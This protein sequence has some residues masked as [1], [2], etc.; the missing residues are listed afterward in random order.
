MYID[1]QKGVF[2]LLVVLIMLYTGFTFGIAPDTVT[3]ERYQLTPAGLRLLLLTITVPLIG[4]WYAAFYGFAR[5]KAYASSIGSSP[6]G[7]AFRQLANGLMVLAVGLPLTSIIPALMKY[8]VAGNMRLIPAATIIEHY[9]DVAIGLIAFTLIG[10]GARMLLS[11]HR[12]NPAPPRKVAVVAG[13]VLFG[14]LFAYV[15]LRNP[16]IQTPATDVEAVYYLPDWL[17][18][19]TI[20]IPYLYIW[21]N[22]LTAAYYV[23]LY[24]KHVKGSLYKQSLRFLAWGLGGVIISSMLL[25][26]FTAFSNVL[27][28]LDLAPLLAVIYLLLVAISAGY[29]LIAA[30]AKRL[31][32]LEEV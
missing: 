13:L 2:W 27:L 20:V 10:K 15:A 18:I 31:Q 23:N 14:G 4:I 25:Q 32:K 11:L 8:I 24:K 5:F 7:Q 22:G 16:A 12:K 26:Y 17:I 30:G 19:A 9:L 28:R 21:Y 29:V 6:D 1:K 3:L